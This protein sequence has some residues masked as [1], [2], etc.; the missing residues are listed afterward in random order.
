[1]PDVETYY[2]GVSQDSE[3][4]ADEIRSAFERTDVRWGP[5][6]T[7]EPDVLSGRR[8]TDKKWQVLA[9][10]FSFTRANSGSGQLQG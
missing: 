3:I 5:L 4:E 6:R 2:N 8:R 1:M 7:P 9:C 10:H